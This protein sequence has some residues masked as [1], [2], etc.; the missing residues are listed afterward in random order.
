[1]VWR[2]TPALTL[3]RPG[4]RARANAR[5]LLVPAKPLEPAQLAVVALQNPRTAALCFDRVWSLSP[6]DCPDPI[7]FNT[8]SDAELFA[9]LSASATGVTLPWRVDIGAMQRA[10]FTAPLE[11]FPERPIPRMVLMLL[12]LGTLVSEDH[13]NAP[14]VEAI[15]LTICEATSNSI[16]RPVLPV[17]SAIRQR[18]VA[19]APGDREVILASIRELEV[20]DEDLVSWEQVVDFRRDAATHRDYR[21]LVHWL[22]CNM[23]GRSR[24]YVI[25][26][27]GTRVERY[28]EALHKHGLKTRLGVLGSLVDAKALVATAVAAGSSLA[29]ENRSGDY[30]ELRATFF[31]RVMLTVGE[32]RLELRDVHA[33]HAEIAFVAELNHRLNPSLPPDSL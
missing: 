7:R 1:M 13:A 10:L 31:G 15:T 26:E 28:R 17:F 23:V 11:D 27:I 19:Y 33:E 18:D 6:E 24:N 2:L 16:G 3:G 30:L 21:R 8:G 20:V 22:D 14:I 12:G 9:A 25:D 5:K 29:Q 32:A 4:S